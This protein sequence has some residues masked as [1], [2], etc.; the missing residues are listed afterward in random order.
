VP[1]TVCSIVADVPKFIKH[2]LAELD[3]RLH[4]PVQIKAGDSI[5]ELISKLADCGL[6]VRLEWPERKPAETKSPEVSGE[7]VQI[8]DEDI[9]F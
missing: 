9:T 5:F 8:T 3:A 1:V 6:E 2:A 4:N 7:Q